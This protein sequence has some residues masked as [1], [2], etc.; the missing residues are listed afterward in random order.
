MLQT[1][2]T[3][4]DFELPSQ[5]GDTVRLS[6]FKGKQNVVL[7]FYPKDDTPGCTKE[8]CTFRDAYAEFSSRDTV[9]LGISSDSGESHG[10]FATKYSLPFPLLADA[11]GKIRK[12]YEV[13]RTLGLMPG[14][15]TYVIDKEGII[16]EIFVSQ[17]QPEEHVRRALNALQISQK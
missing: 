6:D 10:R 4:P 1:G 11:G 3:A 2:D 15:A 13:P 17:F 12:A 5:I 14:R 16:R 8:A 9:V 7:F